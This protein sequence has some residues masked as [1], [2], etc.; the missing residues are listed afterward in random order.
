AIHAATATRAR[1]TKE[2]AWVMGS[3]L[4]SD[5][6][7]ASITRG[8]GAAGRRYG[9][10]SVAAPSGLRPPLLP[11]RSV[12]NLAQE[13]LGPIVLRVLEERVRLVL[14]DDFATV[15]EDDAVGDLAREA[16]LVGDA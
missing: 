2:V 12:Q 15:H 16:H 11:G 8:S 5:C 3:P 10:F 1:L 6:Q 7:A 13:Q 14:L 4:R 9:F